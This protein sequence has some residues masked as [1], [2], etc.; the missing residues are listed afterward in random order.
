MIHPIYK[1]RKCKVIPPYSLELIF[2]DGLS[3]TINLEQI[4]EGGLYGSLKDPAL[5]SKVA[6]DPEIGTIVWENGADFDPAIL[7]DWP[8]HSKDFENAAKRWKNA[9]LSLTPNP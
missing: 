5:F 9:S 3:R 1:I 2:N 6:I 4:L 8:S 7:H